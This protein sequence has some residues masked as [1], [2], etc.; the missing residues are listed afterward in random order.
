VGQKSQENLIGL[1]LDPGPRAVVGILGVLKSGCGFVP[2]DPDYPPERIGFILDDCDIKTLL[3]EARYASLARRV[4]EKNTTLEHIV[5]LDAVESAERE[6]NGIDVYDCRDYERESPAEQ[7]IHT[8]RD[9]TVYVVYTSGST[10]IPKGVPIAHENLIPMLLWGR[11]HLKLGEHSKTLQSLSYCFDFGIFEILSIPTGATKNQTAFPS[12]EYRPTAGSTCWTKT[13][14]PCPWA[15]QE[16]C[17]S[18]GWGCPGV[19]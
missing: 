5:C 9:Q 1:L 12:G 16:S 18:E 7:E 19:T 13:A 3:T 10:G 14:S 11:E 15:C 17:T 6:T 4:A 2:I 8:E